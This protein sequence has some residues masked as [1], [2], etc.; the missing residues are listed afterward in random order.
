MPPSGPSDLRC[1]RQRHIVQGDHQV[2]RTGQLRRQ[3]LETKRANRFGDDRLVLGRLVCEG[4]GGQNWKTNAGTTRGS[5]E[6]VLIEWRG[7]CGAL[8]GI[9]VFCTYRWTATDKDRR[10]SKR[11]HD[12]PTSFLHLELS[13]N[14]CAPKRRVD[15]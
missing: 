6:R 7:M 2:V 11:H 13:M 14:G 9:G 15:D 5:L 3:V 4:L 12:C 8:T 10:D 1:A